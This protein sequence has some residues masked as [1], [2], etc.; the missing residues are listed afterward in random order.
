V[1]QTALA[2]RLTGNQFVHALLFIKQM[3]DEALLEEFNT[4]GFH[5]RTPKV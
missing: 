1:I 3:P 4:R 2:A 5:P